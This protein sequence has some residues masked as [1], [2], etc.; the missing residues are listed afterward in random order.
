MKFDLTPPVQRVIALAIV[1]AILL[2]VFQGIV[3][4]IWAASSLHA[5]Q[6]GMLKRQ[7][8]TMRGLAEAAPRFEALSKKLAANPDIQQLTFSAPQATLAVAQLQGQLSQIFAAASAVVT[9][10]QPMPDVRE[11]SLTKIS[12]QS[13]VEAEVKSLVAALHAIDAA[14]PLLHIDKLVIRDPDGEWAN[15]PQTN[16][17]NKLQIE[18]V[19]SATMR[20]P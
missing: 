9:T 4:P 13:T 14:R 8:L 6:I 3:R 10:S 18:L 7:V 2:L 1:G 17:P 19:V 20:A 12:V 16:A 5:E 15:A 11:G